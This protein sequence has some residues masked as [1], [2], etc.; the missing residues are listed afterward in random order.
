MRFSPGSRLLVKITPLER[1]RGIFISGHRFEPYRGPEIAPWDIALAPEEGKA[2][3]SRSIPFSLKN[4]AI[5]F[6]FFGKTVMLSMLIEQER[7]NA[8]AL[9][10]AGASDALVRLRVFDLKAF[11]AESG[12]AA[13]DYRDIELADPEGSRFLVRPRKAASIA[14]ERRKAWFAA[15][16]EGVE[17]AM[18]GLGRPVEP[19]SF[20]EATFESAPA[21]VREEPAAAFSEYF[22]DGKA[23]QAEEFGGRVFMWG[24]GVSIPELLMSADAPARSRDDEDG[25]S[26]D[27]AAL[28]FALDADEIAAFVRDALWRGEGVE[29]ALARCFIGASELGLPKK[30]L[31]TLLDEARAFAHGVA[32]AWDRSAENP[33]VARIRSALLDIY[34]LFLVW[35]RRMGNLVSSPS[36]L[37]TEEFSLL[38]TA[39]KGVC[40]FIVNLG[41]GQSPEPGNLSGFEKQLPSLGEMIGELMA[42]IEGTLAGK[43]RR[44]RASASPSASKARGGA[45]S[46]A[47]AR[48]PKGKRASRPSSQKLYTFEARLADIEPPIRRRLVVPGNRS[49]AELHTILQ[50]AFGWTD[51]HL[52]LFRFRDKAFGLP[53][54][55]DYEPL[56]DEHEVRLD[57]LSLR[58]RSKIE[59]VYDYG[60]DWEHEL[61]VVATRKATPGEDVA[62]SCLEAERASPPEDCG[63][64]PG[65]EELLEALATPEDER[66]ED[67]SSLVEWAG[68]W[69]AES[70]DLLAINKALGK[71]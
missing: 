5:Y 46:P 10:S 8:K 41:K 50:D 44:R 45:K 63:G 3:A 69:D 14:P 17:A 43:S 6:T 49:L 13:G 65:Y 2:F 71:D 47:K 7:S 21:W 20:M 56:I 70:L 37:D 53:S 32:A 38:S 62:P 39:M 19:S 64:F 22:N 34:A 30:K 59:Y 66:D 33:D 52:H 31:D 1:E 26:R 9:S 24:S 48:T 16:D 67:E 27:L 61:V 68:G 4:V 36:D 40:E 15:M 54:P 29:E 60:D 11:Y 51:S 42:A 35:M 58:V 12:L 55:D 23:L 57:E 25:L 28:G 18:R